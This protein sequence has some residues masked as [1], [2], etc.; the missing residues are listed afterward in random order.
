MNKNDNDNDNSKSN[1]VKFDN[2]YDKTNLKNIKTSNDC[3]INKTIA[4]FDKTINVYV[5][6][7]WQKK[8]VVIIVLPK[9]LVLLQTFQRMHGASYNCV[10]CAEILKKRMYIGIKIS[11][12][13]FS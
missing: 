11:Q 6:N 9:F 7:I 10:Q 13:F 8:I 1:A 3:Y 12:I 5:N 4:L 2:K